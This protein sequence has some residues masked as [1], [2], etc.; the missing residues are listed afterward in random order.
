MMEFMFIAKRKTDQ[1]LHHPVHQHGQFDPGHEQEVLR[2]QNDHS[3]E[4]VHH[5][6][7]EPLNGTHPTKQQALLYQQT[8]WLFLLNTAATECIIST[9]LDRIG[10]EFFFCLFPLLFYFYYHRS[11]FFFL[12]PLFHVQYAI[13]VGF[14]GGGMVVTLKNVK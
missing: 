8:N 7:G 11:N 10:V 4:G 3:P 9:V 14:G 5:L 6:C 2:I 1:V 13:P 12:Y